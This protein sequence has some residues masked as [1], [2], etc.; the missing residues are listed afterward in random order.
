MSDHRRIVARGFR[1]AGW[2]L[3][4]PASLAAVALTIAAVTLG[5]GAAPQPVH[6]LSVT[7]Y[8]LAGLLSNAA[9]AVGG[10]LSLLGGLAAWGL[11]LLAVLALAAALFAALLYGIGRGLGASAAW[12]RVAAAALIGGVAFIGLLLL[13]ILGDGARLA[14]LA[15][16]AASGYALWALGWRFGAPQPATGRAGP[17]PGPP[18]RTPAR[19][20]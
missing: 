6:P 5:A 3:G 11:A 9:E 20:P 10:V 1:I 19:K 8:G 13:P 12:A 17:T 18:A 16:L 7:T 14:D 2:A 4:A 15:A